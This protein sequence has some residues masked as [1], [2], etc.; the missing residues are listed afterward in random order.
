M[1]NSEIREKIMEL[2]IR[3]KEREIREMEDGTGRYSRDRDLDYDG[4]ESYA[5]QIK[6]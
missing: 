3:L 6:D 2:V 5:R 4:I 1:S